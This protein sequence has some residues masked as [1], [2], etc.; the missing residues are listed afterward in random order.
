M[1]KGNSF[2]R[3]FRLK[4][5]LDRTDGV[6]LKQIMHEFNVKK[7]SAMRMIDQMSEL[8]PVS[9]H[10]EFLNKHKGIVYRIEK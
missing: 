6:T 3:A 2:K 7:P 9:E 4:E 1:P 5:M 8:F 10:W